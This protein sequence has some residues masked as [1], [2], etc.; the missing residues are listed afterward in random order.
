MLVDAG[1]LG[2]AARFDM[3][4]RVVAPAMWSRRIGWLDA[5]LVTHGD[6]DHIGGASTIVDVFRPTTFE[7]IVVPSHLPSAT[8][9]A[10]A[11]ARHLDVQS[12]YRQSQWRVGAVVVRVWHPPRPDW[13][14]R[15]VR[16][17]DSVVIELQVTNWSTPAIRAKR[18]F[19]L[20]SFATGIPVMLGQAP[21]AILHDVNFAA[22][23]SAQPSS[24]RSQE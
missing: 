20:R 16:N 13:E 4:A 21:A 12:L 6:P 14:R 8:L 2:G 23:A 17:D 9:R 5:L 7:G 18:P 1:G 22:S 19:E 3:G 11:R 15:R 10:R 24:A